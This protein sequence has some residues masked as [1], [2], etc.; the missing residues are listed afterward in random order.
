MFASSITGSTPTILG[1]ISCQTTKNTTVKA[2]TA[3]MLSTIS[4][5]LCS[6]KPVFILSSNPVTPSAKMNPPSRGT[7]GRAFVNPTIK[8]SQKIQ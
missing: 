6:V 5:F 1:P 8:L 3:T 4:S 7:E 2:R